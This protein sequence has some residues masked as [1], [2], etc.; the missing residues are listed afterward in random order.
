[1]ALYFLA[2][3]CVC[4]SIQE[5]KRMK[6]LSLKYVNKILNSWANFNDINEMLIDT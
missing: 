5:C 6:Y 2:C 1:M 4:K 3:I